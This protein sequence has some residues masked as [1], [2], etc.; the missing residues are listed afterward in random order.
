[1]YG[2]PLHPRIYIYKTA[3]M[4]KL[5]IAS[6]WLFLLIHTMM[7]GSTNITKKNQFGPVAVY[8]IQSVIKDCW[9]SCISWINKRL[10][11]IITMHGTAVEKD[12]V[13]FGYLYVVAAKNTND[14]SFVCKLKPNKYIIMTNIRGNFIRICITVNKI[15]FHDHYI[16]KKPISYLLKY[17]QNKLDI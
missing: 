11:I 5:K 13:L 7:Y 6:Y 1:V 15:L 14:R 12:N 3:G 9:I 17:I 10:Y 2:L 16:I 8:F 4:N